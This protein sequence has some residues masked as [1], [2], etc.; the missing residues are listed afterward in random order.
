MGADTKPVLCPP[1]LAPEGPCLPRATLY[2]IC[3][4]PGSCPVSRLVLFSCSVVSDSLRLHGLQP[5]RLLCP[6]DS[7][8]KNPG[9]VCHSLLQGLFPTQRHGFHVSGIAGGFL[10]TEPPGNPP[11]PVSQFLPVTWGV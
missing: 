1:N 7:P 10:T 3:T 6:W 4:T 11:H 5:A 9:M 2:L 8:G